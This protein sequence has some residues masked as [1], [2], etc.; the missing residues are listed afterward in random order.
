MVDA[1][2]RISAT[3]R[4]VGS[5]PSYHIWSRSVEVIAL[6]CHGR[7]RGFDSLRD[8]LLVYMCELLRGFPHLGKVA[9]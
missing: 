5:S 3:S 8:Y 7:G 4:E 9:Q 2:R 1:V 6:P